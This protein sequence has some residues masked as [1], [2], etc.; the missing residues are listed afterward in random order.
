VSFSA[1]KT[2]SQA[3]YQQGCRARRIRIG[4]A[5]VSKLTKILI[6]GDSWP[7]PSP[8]DV[9]ARAEKARMS[10]RTRILASFL[11]VSAVLAAV[12][13][14][15]LVQFD[16]V[17]NGTHELATE[18]FAGL[19]QVTAIQ[20]IADT[21]VT[22]AVEF[23]YGPADSRDGALKQYMDSVPLMNTKIANLKGLMLTPGQKTAYHTLVEQSSTLTKFANKFLGVKATPLDASAPEI[24]TLDEAGP[25]IDA[26]NATLAQLRDVTQKQVASSESTLSHDYTSSRRNILI[27][28]ALMLLSAVGVA[29]WL[30]GRITG[31]MRRTVTVLDQVAAGD[32]TGRIE[33]QSK[34]E[35]GKMAE[36]LNKTLEQTEAVIRTIRDSAQELSEAS[37]GFTE[38]SNQVARSAAQVEG[39]A[40]AAATGIDQVGEEIGAVAAGA[41]EMTGAVADISRSATQAAQVASSAVEVAARTRETVAKLGESSREVGD[42]VKLIDSIAQQTNL[43][44]LNAT[45]EAARAGE[46]GKGF[47]VV[48][49]EVK[50]LSG[51]TAKATQEIA[52]R[53]DAIQADTDSAVSA[54]A[55]IAIVVEQINDFQAQIAAAVEEQNA[56]TREIDRSASSVAE[57]THEVA[58]R[59]TAVADAVQSTT[60]AVEVN[61]EDAAG[62]AEMSARLHE[63]VSHFVVRSS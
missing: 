3:S 54:I 13:G 11:A 12:T 40:A 17:N 52:S 34:D 16:H 23:Q 29:I 22:N 18:Q 43:L 24:K 48:A 5:R 51:E 50:D 1:L 31:P 62:L 58:T 10:I 27:I 45:I 44:A 32:L 15:A 46:A 57:R 8:T 20:H 2:R 39:Q 4:A 21:A 47:A 19:T 60:S 28:L 26:R 33:I 30:A 14:Y 55:E 63:S 59:I 25:A 9:P 35:I 49:G 6:I 7:M 53:I 61:R 37:A 41:V 38:R 56:T 36:A 42:V